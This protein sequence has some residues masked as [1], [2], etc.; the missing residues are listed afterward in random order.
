M[1]LQEMLTA[2]QEET[3]IQVNDEQEAVIA[4]EDGPLRSS[5]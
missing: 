5:G 3:G 4:H 1:N 2:I